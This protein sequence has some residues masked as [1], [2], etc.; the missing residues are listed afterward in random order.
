MPREPANSI[1]RTLTFSRVLFGVEQADA[2]LVGMVLLILSP[3]LQ[4]LEWAGDTSFSNGGPAIVALLLAM[5]VYSSVQ[6]CLY[7]LPAPARSEGGR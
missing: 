3:G 1:S 6:G 4:A 2:L 7:G 5:G